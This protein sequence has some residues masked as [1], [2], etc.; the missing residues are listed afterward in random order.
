MPTPPPTELVP[1]TEI[2]V[3]DVIQLNRITTTPLYGTVR[4]VRFE[5]FNYVTLFLDGGKREEYPRS[6]KVRRVIPTNT[7]D[8]S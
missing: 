6:S 2:E 4:R 7:E 8:E 5:V 3:G 1:I